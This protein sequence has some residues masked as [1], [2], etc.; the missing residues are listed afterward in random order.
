MSDP[1]AEL[2]KKYGGGAVTVAPNAD[3]WAELEPSMLRKKQRQQSKRQSSH[4][5]AKATCLRTL[6][7]GSTVALFKRSGSLLIQC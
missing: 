7:K 6:L 1:W 4:K 2:E 5:S 3:P